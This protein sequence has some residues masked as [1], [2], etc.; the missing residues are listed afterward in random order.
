M[1]KTKISKKWIQNLN[2]LKR[3]L[4]C[5]NFIVKAR[6]VGLADKMSKKF[7]NNARILN[8]CP[9]SLDNFFYLNAGFWEQEH[10]PTQYFEQ[11][12][13]I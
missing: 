9:L 8:G 6:Y 5:L 4:T 7:G 11:L 10:M 3:K 2:H 12:V 13:V 1:I